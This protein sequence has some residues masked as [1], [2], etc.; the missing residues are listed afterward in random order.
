MNQTFL[1]LAESFNV[2]ESFHIEQAVRDDVQNV[3][4]DT[5]NT[6]KDVK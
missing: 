1:K 6:L 3:R 2:T 4:G 5:A